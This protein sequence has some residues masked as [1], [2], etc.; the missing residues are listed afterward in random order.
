MVGEWRKGT[1]ASLRDVSTRLAV[2]D[3]TTVLEGHVLM[4]V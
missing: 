4:M 1:R 3:T 2:T